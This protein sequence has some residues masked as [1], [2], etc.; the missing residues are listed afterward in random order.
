MEAYLQIFIVLNVFII[1]TLFGSFFSLATYRLPR[2]Q[3]IVSTRSY[4]PNC[5]HNLGFLDLIP[6]LSYLFSGAKCRYCSEHI[7]ARYILMELT[8]GLLFI[9]VYLIF[10]FSFIS[11]AIIVIYIAMF[12]FLGTKIME[13]KMTDEEKKEVEMKNKKT[14]KLKFSSKKGV[15]ISELVVAA[16]IFAVFLVS[17][18]ISIR[19]YDSNMIATTAKSDA[20]NIAVKNMEI[21]L[22]TEYDELYSFSDTQELNS[23][24]YSV[25]INV[26]KY[27]DEFLDKEDLIKT[28][29]VNVDYMLNG[30][31][32]NFKVSSLKEKEI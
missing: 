16:I 19:N 18:I 12:I 22:A 29:E 32:Q 14:T 17:S 20:V 23:I 6:V 10:G 13:N 1:G 7:S 5:K 25:T 21:A 8:N 11:L 24:E 27:S 9:L 3:D 28:V 26:I 2:K 15:F 30:K 4:C 31:N